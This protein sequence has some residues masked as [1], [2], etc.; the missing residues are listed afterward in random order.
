MS[1]LISM[2]DNRPLTRETA[3]FVQLTPIGRI[4]Q[5]ARVW[6]ANHSADLGTYLAR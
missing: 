1:P 4:Q 5:S 6:V 2:P 3:Q